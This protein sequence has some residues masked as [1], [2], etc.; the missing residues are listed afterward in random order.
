VIYDHAVSERWQRVL[1]WI[2]YSDEGE[3]EMVDCCPACRHALDEQERPD[4]QE[5]LRRFADRLL[6][7]PTLAAQCGS[8]AN[9]SPG[10]TAARHTQCRCRHPFHGS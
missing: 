8:T 6:R 7:R 3:V 1:D 9:V 10:A 2:S 5:T 4:L